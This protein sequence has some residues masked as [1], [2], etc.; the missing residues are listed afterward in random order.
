MLYNTPSSSL[1][2]VLPSSTSRLLLQVSSS[3]AG[4]LPA[5]PSLPASQ[6]AIDSLSQSVRSTPERVT[7]EAQ[8]TR[9]SST[10]NVSQI[11]FPRF[12][13][14]LMQAVFR[15]QFLRNKLYMSSGDGRTGGRRGW[16]TVPRDPTGKMF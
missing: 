5:L 8:M 1:D 7:D 12:P 13:D 2:V 4:D 6:P 14:K 16:Q 15:D 10:A 9:S 3:P 11:F